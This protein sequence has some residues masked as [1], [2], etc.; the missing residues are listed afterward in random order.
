VLT[1]ALLAVVALVTTACGASTSASS[2][3]TTGVR[4]SDL[5]VL[6]PDSPTQG[7]S[8]T[9]DGSVPSYLP[10]GVA[11]TFPTV[12]PDPT[13]VAAL[14]HIARAGGTAAVDGFILPPRTVLRS[15]PS[16]AAREIGTI[17]A[18]HQVFSFDPLV[19]TDATGTPWL[20]FFLACSGD[21]LYWVSVDELRRD[22]PTTGAAVAATLTG[23]VH[24]RPYTET[25]QASLLP[26]RLLERHLIWDD[27]KL[28]TEP[29]RGMLFTGAT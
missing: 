8:Y 15:G 4:V 26:V 28:P 7:C 11:P 22:V 16:T 5:A 14:H 18:G 19:W 27:K 17:P 23:L 10:T 12:A 3:P 2:T 29:A 13:A 24:A 9:V 25:G 1:G 6:A 20:A 21:Q